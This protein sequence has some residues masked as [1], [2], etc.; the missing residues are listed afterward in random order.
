MD[1]SSSGDLAAFALRPAVGMKV[2]GFFK[3]PDAGESADTAGNW[4]PGKIVSKN[5]DGMWHVVFE[6]GDEGDYKGL[7]DDLRLASGPW[8][9]WLDAYVPDLLI[10][11]YR[12]ARR[13]PT[14][15]S[16]LEPVQSPELFCDLGDALSN[17]GTPGQAKR[18]KGMQHNI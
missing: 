2:E 1:H 5:A 7:E 9:S 3:D 8:E 15:M 13:D 12:A 18:H 10:S 16:N 11:A 17:A 6:D 4:Y 14:L